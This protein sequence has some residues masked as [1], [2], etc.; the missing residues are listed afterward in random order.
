VT[1]PDEIGLP[2]PQSTPNLSRDD[3]RS[4]KKL[5]AEVGRRLIA[6]A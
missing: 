6:G 2:D 4:M 3:E 1:A 5:L